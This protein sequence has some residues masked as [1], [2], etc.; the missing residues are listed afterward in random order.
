M[1]SCARG[2]ATVG[3]V[4]A[5]AQERL[6]AHKVPRQVVALPALPRS[7]V[8]KVLKRELHLPDDPSGSPVPPAAP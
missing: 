5:Y 2:D 7:A 6:A 4:L 8:G 3:E 1:S